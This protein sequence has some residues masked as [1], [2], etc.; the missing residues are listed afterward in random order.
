MRGLHEA[1][2]NKLSIRIDGFGDLGLG[3]VEG[4]E[5]DLVGAG[6]DWSDDS[7]LRGEF[8]DRKIL[9]ILFIKCLLGT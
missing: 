9:Q 3:A 2:W 8:F 6:V 4:L 5:V 1:A 7:R